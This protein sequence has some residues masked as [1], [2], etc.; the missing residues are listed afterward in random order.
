VGS[1]RL[2]I[3][4]GYVFYASTHADEPSAATGHGVSSSSPETPPQCPCHVRVFHLFAKSLSTFES[5]AKSSR[6]SVLQRAPPPAPPG[7]AASGRS[8]AHARPWPP[9]RSRTLR[10]NGAYPLGSVHR[11]PVHRVHD[12]VH[13]FLSNWIKDPWLNQATFF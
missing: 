1:I 4:E 8:P 10:L 3:V 6:T 12:V 7:A 2:R 5:V 9:N 11:G 13:G